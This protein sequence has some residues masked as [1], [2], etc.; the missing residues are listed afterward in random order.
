MKWQL[1]HCTVGVDQD[2]LRQ[3][4]LLRPHDLHVDHSLGLLPGRDEDLLQEVGAVLATAVL[5]NDD[6]QDST[7]IC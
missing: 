2:D 4:L 1:H 3:A 7:I 6:F 5:D